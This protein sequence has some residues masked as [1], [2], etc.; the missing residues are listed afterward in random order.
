[1]V[2]YGKLV[3]MRSSGPWRYDCSCT[4]Y[5]WFQVNFDLT[6]SRVQKSWDTFVSL[7]HFPIH[8]GPTPPVT[9]QT[10][11]DAYIQNFFRVST[12]Y[13]VGEGRTARNFWKGCTRFKRE[14]RMTEKY[15]YCSTVP[16]TFV[17]DCRL[18]LNF[19][20]F[21]VWPNIHEKLGLGDKGNWEST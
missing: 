8:T 4:W 2:A 10:M 5:I 12:L 13:R 19:L 3:V 17:Q 14:P 18:I 9:A 7:E 15:E 21:P 11:L 16:R 6:Y 20:Y 1:M